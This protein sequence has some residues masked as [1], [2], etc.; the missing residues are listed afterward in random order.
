M[1]KSKTINTFLDCRLLNEFS[2]VKNI[3]KLLWFSIPLKTQLLLHISN[4]T[5]SEIEK[6]IKKN[7]TTLFQYH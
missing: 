5:R 2:G 6:I 7:Y 3:Y 4:F 1:K